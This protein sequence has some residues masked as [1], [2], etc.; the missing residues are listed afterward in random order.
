MNVV[1][2]IP[3]YK[4]NYQLLELVQ[5]LARQ[6]LQ[7]IVIVNDGSPGEFDQI[8]RQ[9]SESQNTILLQ[10]VKNLGK[11]AALK[12]GMDYILDH[13]PDCVGVVTAD[14]DGQHSVQN[15]MDVAQS[16]IHH[17]R[18]LTLGVRTFSVNTPARSKFGNE[19]TKLVVK[20]FFGLQVTDTQTGLRGIPRDVIPEMLEISYNRYE[21]EMEALLMCSRRRVSIVEVP[22]VTIYYEDNAGS[23]FNPVLDSVKIY[24][25]LFRYVISSFITACIDYT[26]FAISYPFFGS[27]W[28]AT[29]LARMVAI[30]AN[31]TMVRK[32]VFYSKE[33]VVITFIKYL[34]LV[35]ISGFI[36]ALMIRFFAAEWGIN[37]FLAKLMAEGILYMINFIIQKNL[38]F[39]L[40]ERLE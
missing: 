11:G 23:H 33:N 40:K 32:Y 30:M 19:L 14:A 3:A 26:V 36:S 21:F 15:I 35:L 18:S 22:I 5:D 38:I 31:F 4:P 37:I 9:V 1:I 39:G 10:H 12:M 20:I 7:K 17:P 24:F 13:F 28:S 8:F 6:P 34:C 29:Y 2:L 25:V 16:L 27:I